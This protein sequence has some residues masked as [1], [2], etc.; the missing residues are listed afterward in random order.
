MIAPE[1]IKQL[2]RRFNDAEEER[3]ILRKANA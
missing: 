2:R 1:E 3:E